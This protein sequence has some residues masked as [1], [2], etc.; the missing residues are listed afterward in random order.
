MRLTF[1][2]QD[3][4]VVGSNG[5]NLLTDPC[6]PRV[7][8][9]ISLD[10]LPR[11]DAIIV[12][13]SD[14]DALSWK[15]LE[16]LRKTIPVIAPKGTEKK[17]GKCGFANVHEVQSGKAF[18]IGDMRVITLP[19]KS[20]RDSFGVLFSSAKNAY[21]A[22]PTL[23]FDKMAAIGS[24]YEVDLALLPIGGR[25]RGRQRGVMTP[26]EAAD[27]AVRLKAK[28]V[29]PI[30]WHPVRVGESEVRPS[31]T[32]EEFHRVIRERKLGTR[33]RVLRPSDAIII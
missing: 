4:V 2:W 30:H 3:C 27:A 7:R 8:K 23:Y 24:T 33:V 9:V 20:S 6:F 5:T 21:F 28:S 17:I 10:D 25:F 12:S 31:G 26:E 19:A 18:T 11:L 13:N 29:V 32:P 14:I 22:G 16:P 1:V 15:P